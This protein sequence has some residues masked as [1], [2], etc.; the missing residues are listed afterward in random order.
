MSETMFHTHIKPSII[1]Y[2]HG[3]RTYYI[4]NKKTVEHVYK[5]YA[6]IWLHREIDCHCHD[7]RAT[8]IA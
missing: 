2:I 1:S 3:N 8:L 5:W 4:S 6:K 7:C